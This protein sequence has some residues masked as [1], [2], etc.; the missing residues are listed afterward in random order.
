MLNIDRIEFELSSL[1][2]AKCS[3]CLRTKLDN[4]SIPYKK[5]YIPL[6]NITRWFAD[7]DLTNTQLKFCGVLGDPITN[8]ELLD[9]CFYFLF[10]KKVKGIEISTNGGLQNKNFWETL[11]NFSY[12]SKYKLVVHWAI[13]GYSRNDYREN[14]NLQK[15]WENVDYYHN[16]KGKSLWQYIKFDYNKDEI[17]LAKAKAKE[18][19][20]NFI[21]RENWRN[22]DRSLKYS[23]TEA[24]TIE[25]LTYAEFEDH[26]I[27]NSYNTNNIECKYIN[28]H[29]LYIGVDHCLWPCCYLYAE[30][31]SKLSFKKIYE[32]YG[33][34]FNNLNDYDLHTIL[35]HT[36]FANIK[37][38]WNINH[39]DHL[40]R[41]YMSCGDCGKRL[42]QKYRI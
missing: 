31:T 3:G 21:V 7:I 12:R 27:N 8:P 32:K 22:N 29:E 42:Q 33:K 23:S 16:A 25:S 37:S 40:S 35:N 10:V 1:C 6:H 15:V 2:N 30:A 39:P 18:Y 17:A 34:N 14:V 4:H 26:V 20:M 5:D 41:C 11:G 9:I 28:D 19:N 36:W 24:S 13:D 38:S